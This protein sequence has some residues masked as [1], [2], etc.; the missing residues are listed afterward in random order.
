MKTIAFALNDEYRETFAG[1][2]VARGDGSG[3]DVGGALKDGDGVIVVD[4]A[5]H[6]LIDLLRAVDALEEVD[7]PTSYEDMGVKALRAAAKRRGLPTSGTKSELIK[8][9]EDN[10]NPPPEGGDDSAG[11]SGEEA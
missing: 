6:Q 7:A 8:R 4:E 5:D 10:D 9:L 11:A 2:T 3:F 1:A